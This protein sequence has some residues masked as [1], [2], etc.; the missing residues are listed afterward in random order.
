MGKKP[1][2]E[3]DKHLFRK[4][5]T[6]VKP[7]AEGQQLKH[8]KAVSSRNKP[9]SRAVLDEPTKLNALATSGSQLSFR[10]SHV[11][12]QVFRDLV[13]GR[14][15]I[16]DELDLHGLTE[17]QAEQALIRFIQSCKQHRTLCVLVIHGKGQSA[18]DNRPILKNMCNDIL[19][20][21]SDVAAFSSAR[22]TNGGTGAVYV[23]LNT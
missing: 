2:S 17:A 20:R 4:A 15:P 3:S 21:M 5:V 10:R 16:E 22:V 6:D 19:R 9:K 8:S 7:L 18:E 11:S 1:L 13:S 14:V 12:D 23:L